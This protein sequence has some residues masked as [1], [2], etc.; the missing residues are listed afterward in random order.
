[1]TS[2]KRTIQAL[3]EVV[4]RAKN[5][6]AMQE[7]YEKTVGLEVWQSYEGQVFFRIGPGYDGHT[8]ILALFEERFAA[9]HSGR[10]YVGLEAATS[11]LHHFAL[12][13]A[14]ADY[15]VEIDRLRGLGIT[16]ETREHSWTHWRSAYFLDPEGNVV[17]FVCYDAAV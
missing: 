9:D 8:Q 11:T 3:G 10:A 7:F 2:P 15:F 1:M 6:D 12:T 13:I 17:E 5:L 4:L 14:L 16:V